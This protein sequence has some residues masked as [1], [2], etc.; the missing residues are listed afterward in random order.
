M[1]SSKNVNIN[2][3]GVNVR[4]VAVYVFVVIL[5]TIFI[6]WVVLA[7]TVSTETDTFEGVSGNVIQLVKVPQVAHD[8]QTIVLISAIISVVVLISLIIFL[9]RLKCD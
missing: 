4:L 5:F 9:V 3:K 2:S 8:S 1:K 7:K 6:S